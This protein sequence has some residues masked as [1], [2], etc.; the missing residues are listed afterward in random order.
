M[1]HDETKNAYLAYREKAREM[2]SDIL[3]EGEHVKVSQHANVQIAE[4]GAFVE[5]TVWVPKG[6]L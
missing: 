5:C 3:I 4:D 6:K 2:L 1:T